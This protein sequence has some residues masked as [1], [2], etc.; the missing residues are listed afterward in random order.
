MGAAAYVSHIK[1]IWD[2]RICVEKKE[3]DYS[4]P[5]L[6]VLDS[7]FKLM[8]RLGHVS[9]TDSKKSIPYL[10]MTVGILKTATVSRNARRLFA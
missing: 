5:G 8:E 1:W 6:W 2:R 3:K 7:D 9:H 4:R 10:S